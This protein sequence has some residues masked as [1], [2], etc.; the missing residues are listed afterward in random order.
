M[1]YFDTLLESVD[2]CTARLTPLAYAILASQCAYLKANF[3][4]EYRMAAQ[5][6]REGD[7]V[8]EKAP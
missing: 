4:E 3:P 5:V 8:S 1:Q 7:A 6:V 2:R